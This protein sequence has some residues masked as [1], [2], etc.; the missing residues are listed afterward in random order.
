[1]SIMSYGNYNSGYGYDDEYYNAFDRR[2]DDNQEEVKR[3]K[4]KIEVINNIQEKKIFDEDILQEFKV[5][6]YIKLD[7][8]QELYKKSGKLDK[9]LR[10]NIMHLKIDV[11]NDILQLGFDGKAY[12][13]LTKDEIMQN[14]E[15]AIMFAETS[16]IYQEKEINIMIDIWLA[17]NKLL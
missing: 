1:M 11:V 8:F 3:R 12:K 4:T 10:E 5:K 14:L 15:E 9:K 7:V 17:I 16:S 6:K 2:I 13:S